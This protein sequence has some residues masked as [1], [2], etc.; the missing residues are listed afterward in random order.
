MRASCRCGGQWWVCRRFHTTS[1]WLGAQ[2]GCTNRPDGR[3]CAA[4]ALGVDQ[5][6]GRISPAS[7]R[8]LQ[9]RSALS[10]LPKVLSS[11]EIAIWLTSTANLSSRPL[12]HPAEISPGWRAQ[13]GEVHMENGEL[14]RLER[15]PGERLSCFR[16]YESRRK[17]CLARR[18]ETPLA[19]PHPPSH[20][21]LRTLVKNCLE[22]AGTV[23]DATQKC[24]RSR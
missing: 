14:K 6:C 16:R 20:A 23:R 4:A 15:S 7:E 24:D 21:A 18:R 13:A 2:K 10:S 11:L 17:Q 5:A 8:P 22:V 19:A 12:Q 3:A 9:P 1:C